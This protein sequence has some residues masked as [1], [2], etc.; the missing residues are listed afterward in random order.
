MCVP[1]RRHLITRRV[2]ISEKFHVLTRIPIIQLPAKEYTNQRVSFNEASHIVTAHCKCKLFVP[3][4]RPPPLPPSKTEVK[5]LSH[6]VHDNLGSV[7][8]T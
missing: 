3:P 6:T 1:A 7:Q 8:H 2:L 4:V 5:G